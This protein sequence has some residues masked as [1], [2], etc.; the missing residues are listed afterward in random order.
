MYGIAGRKIDVAC[1]L[2]FLSGRCS[3]LGRVK[4]SLIVTS[5]MEDFK[6]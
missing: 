4:D 1:V 3:C 2:G 5:R 6:H